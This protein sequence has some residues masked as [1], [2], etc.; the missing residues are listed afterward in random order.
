MLSRA[1]LAGAD[2]AGRPA[3]SADTPIRVP[4]VDS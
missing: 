2:R 4:A 1:G 3:E